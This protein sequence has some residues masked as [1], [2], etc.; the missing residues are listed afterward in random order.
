MKDFVFEEPRDFYDYIKSDKS[1]YKT[2]REA[3]YI[4]PYDDFLIGESGGFLMNI[5]FTFIDV[6]LLTPAAKVFERDGVYTDEEVDSPNYTKFRRKEEHRRKTGYS[7]PCKLLPDGTV[8]TLHITGD[9]YN[10][11]NYGRMLRLDSVRENGKTGRKKTGFPRFVD[12]QYWWFKIK[13]F[14][15]NNGFNEIVCKTRRGGFSYS[16]G[17][18]T[19]NE[20]NL[21]ADYT[22]LLAAEL[23]DYL[24]QGNA[25]A[26]M[27]REQIYFYEDYTPFSRG[28]ISRKFENLKLGYK[29]AN[30]NDRGYKSKMICASSFNN[31]DCAI[32]K[33]AVKVKAEEIGKFSNFNEFMTQTGPTLR[34][35]A[36]VTGKLTA[37]GT[38]NADNTS[39]EVFSHN[40]YNPSIWDFMAFE[41][42]WD[43]NSRHLTC[44]YYKPFWWGLEG[45]WEG[46]SAMDENGN[47]NYNVAIKIVEAEQKSTWEE[48]KNLKEYGDYI[49]QYGNRPEDSFGAAFNNIFVSDGLIKH[50]NA[51]TAGV[52]PVFYRDGK[53][54]PL[55]NDK[56]KITG[57]KFYTNEQL[58]QQ[59]R[60]E[61]IHEYIEALKPSP[62]SDN[63]GCFREF[64]P[65]MLI[66]GVVPEDLYRIWVDPYGVDKDE[67][68]EITTDN[69]FGSIK[70]Y[71]KS[72]NIHGELGDKLVASFVGRPPKQEDFDKL[73]LHCSYRYNAKVFTEN[74]RGQVIQ[75]FRHWGEHYRLVPEPS[76]A[77]DTK[78]QGKDGRGFG[79]SIG[80]GSDR[81]LNGILFYKEW[82]YTKRGTDISGEPI[83]NYHTIVDKGDLLELK[84]FNSKGNFDRI[85]TMIVGAY[86]MK[87]MTYNLSS[88]VDGKAVVK[89]ND[90]TGIFKRNW[91]R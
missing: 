8:T 64:D 81:K 17:I 36:Y 10:F 62:T 60:H 5:S 47:T 69:S 72:T 21:N 77:W 67:N 85:S 86:D 38:I 61:E 42:V 91:Y 68:K 14:C 2:A 23:K 24:T 7:A 66:N 90:G 49:G 39:R 89:T 80:Q 32:G 75:D 59:N 3:G 37:F 12:A 58:F 51:V 88:F 18:D 40:F 65:P 26:N 4:D 30:G 16:E 45:T 35:G 84:T 54:T 71:M 56:G 19:A 6:H 25:I 11:L 53:Y 76:L 15:T 82:L 74:D 44:G 27:A 79:I 70:V 55:R 48:A 29:D 50:I 46:Q 57:V 13:E 1:H 43:N 78:L 83:Y 9:H 31:P 33:D 87:E 41:N 22:V 20:I 63:H 34:T 73:L 52:V 28:L